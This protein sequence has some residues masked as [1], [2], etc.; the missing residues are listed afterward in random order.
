MSDT[1]VSIPCDDITLE[2]TLSKPDDGISH[3]GVVICHPHP[4]RGGDMYNNV[5]EAVYGELAARQIVALRFNFRGVGASGGSAHDSSGHLDDIRAAVDYLITLEEVDPDRIGLAGYSYGA[6][7]VLRYAVGDERLRAI[8]V[9]SPAMTPM[10]HDPILK[11]DRPKYLISGEKDGI[12]TLS[13]FNYLVDSVMEPKQY[14]VAA[15]VD[16]F[17]VGY[18]DAMAGDVA[19][20]LQNNI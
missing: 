17:W 9:V 8:A 6:A 7:M 4:L 3:T 10:R 20:F 5:V 18:E 13:K 19:E 15:G 2:G 14:T 1:Y 12:V 16:H 11:Y